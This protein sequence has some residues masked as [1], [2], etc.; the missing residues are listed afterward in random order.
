MMVAALGAAAKVVLRE[1]AAL[2]AHM[3][4][5]RATLVDTLRANLGPAA[6]R[7]LENGPADASRR[8]PNTASVSV[9]GLDAAALLSELGAGC[10]PD[11]PGV[12]APAGAAC[13]S[14]DAKPSG[15]L[16]AMGYS[17]ERMRGTM[18][19]SVGRHTTWEEVV[20]AAGIL[21]RGVRQQLGLAE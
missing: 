18:R 12:A 6:D 5:L 16:A 2:T 1:Q 10:A 21:A 11:R 20:Q 13:H 8:L 9:L 15:V 17:V 14:A 7:L 19:L 3:E 4:A